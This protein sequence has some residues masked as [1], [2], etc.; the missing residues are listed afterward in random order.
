MI[1]RIQEV[2]IIVMAVLCLLSPTRATSEQPARFSLVISSTPKGLEMIAA[3]GCAWKRLTYSCSGTAA[4]SAEV[5][6]QGVRGVPPIPLEQLGDNATPM[7]FSFIVTQVETGLKI[8]STSGC[9]WKS[10]AYSCGDKSPC[11]AE[12]SETGV[13]TA[14]STAIN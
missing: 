6:D 14:P 4:C 8:R 3:D 5:S 10:L 9:A 7:R 2:R 11:R 12:V 1:T 13:R